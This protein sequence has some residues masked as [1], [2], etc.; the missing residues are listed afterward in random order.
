MTQEQLHHMIALT[1]DSFKHQVHL[2]SS[3]YILIKP[4]HSSPNGRRGC[5]TAFP[6]HPEA[7]L[8]LSC[9][10]A[11]LLLTS[12]RGER[13]ATSTSCLQQRKLHRAALPA[14]AMMSAVCKIRP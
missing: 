10:S 4:T 14:H 8:K 1:A 6:F 11:L 5:S 7:L 12:A 2:A 3:H 13:S 9:M